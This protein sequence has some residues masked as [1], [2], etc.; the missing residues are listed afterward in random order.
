MVYNEL[1]RNTKINYNNIEKDL[2]KLNF[3]IILII[4][5]P[6]ITV[7]KKRIQDR[8]NIYPHYAR[9]LKDPSF[10]IKQQE[11]YL[12]AIEQT[13]LPYLIVQTDQLPDDSLVKKILEWIKE[14]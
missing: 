2:Q 8:L 7:L 13:K 6:K 14:I 3:K 4:F 5:P 10:Y 12:N 11:E 1:Y 9:I